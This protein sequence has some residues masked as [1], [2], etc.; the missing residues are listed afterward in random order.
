[1][2]EEKDLP[3]LIKL[4]K[5]ILS[6]GDGGSVTLNDF[7]KLIG[8]KTE[9]SERDFEALSDILIKHKLAEFKDWG[10][11][12]L[13]LIKT[14]KTERTNIE[15]IFKDKQLEKQKI[16]IEYKDITHTIEPKK[17]YSLKSQSEIWTIVGGIVS[18]LA[19]LFAFYTESK[20]EKSK[21]DQSILQKTI[22]SLDKLP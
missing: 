19:L 13:H 1:M 11:N 9:H 3:L 17:F 5:L 10:G 22:D 14:E 2:I 21:Q 4:Q 18:F 6:K 8:E 15:D 7:I 16:D 20:S 12:S